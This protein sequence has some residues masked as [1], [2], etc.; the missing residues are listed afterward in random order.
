MPTFYLDTSALLKRYKTE[1]GTPVIDHL[2]KVLERPKNKAVIS[3]LTVLEVFAAGKRLLQGGVLQELEFSM[4]LRNFLADTTRYFVLR[5]LDA[6]LF[7]RAIELTLAHG[8]RTADALQL[9]TAL[10]LK[11]LL[12]RSQEKLIFVVDDHEL[13]NAAR[14]E[15][16]EVINPRAED[17]R[18]R[19]EQLA[20]N[21]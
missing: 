1:E 10:E 11:G 5:G 8:L 6:K 12:A 9:A 19:L 18:K 3:F 21:C 2:F 15:S 16:L 20:K 4:L 7:V 17:A 13:Y 14:Q